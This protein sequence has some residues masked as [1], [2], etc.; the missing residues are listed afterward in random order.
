MN[1]PLFV[2]MR[3]LG[4][5]SDKEIIKLIVL[6]LSNIYYKDVMEVLESSIDDSQNIR[7][8]EEALDFISNNL[9]NIPRDAKNKEKIY[10]SKNITN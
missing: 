3:A 10:T 1:I 7:T 4:F 6:D 8:K 5:E 2:L 9:T